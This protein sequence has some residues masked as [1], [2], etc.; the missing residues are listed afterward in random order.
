[1]KEGRRL[2]NYEDLSADITKHYDAIMDSYTR[3]TA[4]NAVVKH[5]RSVTMKAQKATGAGGSGSA[6]PIPPA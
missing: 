1:M 4:T 6:V 3:P 5:L 2:G